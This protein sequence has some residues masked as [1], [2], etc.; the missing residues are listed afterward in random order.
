[1]P[2]NGGYGAPRK[3][4]PPETPLH[5]RS[6]ASRLS[7]IAQD[8]RSLHLP[9]LE[10]KQTF[11]CTAW[12]YDLAPPLVIRIIKLRIVEIILQW[13]SLNCLLRQKKYAKL[14]KKI[15]ISFVS[16]TKIL[17]KKRH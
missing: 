4:A 1:M 6:G 9:Y 17:S 8:V 3:I 16:D 2:P 12:F 15:D 5:R 7:P 13:T 10:I 11:E 14:S